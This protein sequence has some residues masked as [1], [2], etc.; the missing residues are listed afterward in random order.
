MDKFKITPAERLTRLP[1]YLFGQLN[2]MRHEKR[3]A[4]I[5]VI[6]L[7]MGNPMDGAPAAV[8]EKLCEA[9]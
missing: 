2:T 9:A 1:P 4:G 3:Q 8:V 6:D 7:G 5:D